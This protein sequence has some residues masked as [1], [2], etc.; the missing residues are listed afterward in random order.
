MVRPLIGQ[1]RRLLAFREAYNKLD[2]T[3]IDLL[4]RAI[5]LPGIKQAIYNTNIDF[6]SLL[7]PLLKKYIT[8]PYPFL[9][10]PA[11]KK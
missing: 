4:V 5:T 2:N 6:I 8:K 3:G 9:Q 7:H 1:V 11:A 10:R